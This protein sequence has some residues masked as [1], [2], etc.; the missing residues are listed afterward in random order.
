MYAYVNVPTTEWAGLVNASSHGSYHYDSI[1]LEYPYVE[2][3]NFHD[4]LPE[5]PAPDS[6]DVPDDIPA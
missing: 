3:T 6:E 5:G 2:I 4:R 1:R